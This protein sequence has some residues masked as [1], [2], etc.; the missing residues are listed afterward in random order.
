[1][2]LV[3]PISFLR[4]IKKE[5]E[6][7]KS[8]TW[9]QTWDHVKQK[10]Y[11]FD[12]W[13]MRWGPLWL[14]LFVT[15]RCTLQCNFCYYKSPQR[16]RDLLEFNDMSLETF[17]RIIDKFRHA[18]GLGL[19]GGEPFLNKDIFN[20]IKYAHKHKIRVEIP[21]N[22]TIIHDLID[23]I[24]DSPLS[25]L[26][27]SLDAADSNEYRR[28]RGGSKKIFET[29]VENIREL[30]EKR[31]KSNS[32]LT[33]RVSFICTKE[34]YQRIPEK[35]RLAEDLGVDIVLFD[36]LIPGGIP[37]FT[38]DQCLYDDDY[39]VIEVIKSIEKPRSKLT[40]YGPTLYKRNIVER[41]CRMPFINLSI[42]SEGDISTC[43][44]IPPH[45]NHGNIFYDKNVWNNLAY[46]RTRR[47]LLD[48]SLPL[49]NFCKT[50]HG[51]GSERIVINEKK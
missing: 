22:G 45:R 43:C 14:V 38:E 51:L 9:L 1:M 44:M 3:G 4:F 48:K 21:T 30:V 50:C 7:K 6:Y 20:M 33:L 19:T 15:S 13:Y 25:L 11:N 42:D 35:V 40:V 24:I 8:H 16:P 47:I 12:H 34:N 41:R 46:Q 10:I 26:N 5:M 32:N 27:I 29:V 23:R 18:Y 2:R 36:N 17:V 37:S 39:D 31:N 28:M 49:P